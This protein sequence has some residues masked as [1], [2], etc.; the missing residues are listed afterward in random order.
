MIGI[1]PLAGYET[2]FL[3]RC[4]RSGWRLPASGGSNVELD[5]GCVALIAVTADGI[6]LVAPCRPPP[7][8]F[9]RP[10]SVERRL[11]LSAMPP[12]SNYGPRRRAT[13]LVAVFSAGDGLLWAKGTGSA[14]NSHPARVRAS[15]RGGFRA[16]SSPPRRPA[17]RRGRAYHDPIGPL[18]RPRAVIFQG[19]LSWPGQA[20]FARLA[21]AGGA[22]RVWPGPQPDQRD[23]TGGGHPSP[24][25]VTC[26]ILT[27]HNAVCYTSGYNLGPRVFR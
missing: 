3:V 17:S 13:V 6:P 23:S 15:A 2:P 1:L 5:R 18:V 4:A 7:L 8:S 10:P 25:V 27:M 22:Q 21:V 19:E 12:A 20:Q 9:H 26:N 24:H 11:W 14:A 16:G